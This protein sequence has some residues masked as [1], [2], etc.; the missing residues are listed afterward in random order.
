[1]AKWKFKVWDF[2]MV[3]YDSTWS[4]YLAQY[5]ATINWVSWKRIVCM[6]MDSRFITSS[7]N[8]KYV[9]KV[10]K[11]PIGSSHE[12]TYEWHKYTVTIKNK[13]K[14]IKDFPCTGM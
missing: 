5:V 12:F 9:R 11:L 8:P 7:Y 1:M 10:K 4:E 13:G 6:N 3:K 14:R 2:V